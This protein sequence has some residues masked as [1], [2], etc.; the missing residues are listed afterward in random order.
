[1]RAGM[2]SSASWGSMLWQLALKELRVRYKSPA[3]GILWAFAVPLCLSA[4][5]AVV[6][7]RLMP[8]SI[9]GTPYFLF[10]LA[11]IFPWNSVHA[12]ISAATTS[13]Q[14]NGRLIRQIR[15][16]RQLIPWSIVAA[17]FTNFL[18][19]L[20]VVGGGIILF[21]AGGRPWLW[22]LPVAVMLQLL[23]AGGMALLV[24]AWQAQYRDIKYV[25]EVALLLWFYLT[26]VIYPASSVASHGWL[27]YALLSNPMAGLVGL[28]RTGLLGWEAAGMPAGVSPLMLLG[29]T[30]VTSVVCAWVGWRAF[31]RRAATLADFV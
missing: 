14:D 17:H 24:A 21:G 12:T 31:S 8:A 9:A 11:G 3:L 15:F 30:L 19:A 13:L 29:V 28:Y 10:L 18:C 7:G 5:L 26:P 22:M 1:M 25:V 6:F 16:P 23:F 2:K 27:R 20:A 4:V